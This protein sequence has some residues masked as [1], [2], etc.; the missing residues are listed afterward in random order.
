MSRSQFYND[1]VKRL[2]AG[3]QNFLD[4]GCGFG[5]DIR[6]LAIAGCDTSKLYALDLRKEF[7]EL[8]YELFRDQKKIKSPFILADILADNSTYPKELKEL[9]GNVDVMYAGSL[10]H[11]FDYEGQLKVCLKIVQILRPVSGSVVMGR[12][13]GNVVAGET[14]RRTNPNKSMFR[15]NAESFEKMWQEV[16]EKTGTKWRVEAQLLKSE[17][18][19]MRWDPNFRDLHFAVF[20]E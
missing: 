19:S 20:R 3:N 4:L 9:I 5:Q 15:H 7:W 6:P 2:K 10:I 18:A 12:Q 1:I 14:P 17:S 16:G 8:G 13:V 11:L